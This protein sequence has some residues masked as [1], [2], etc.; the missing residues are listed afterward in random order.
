MYKRQPVDETPFTVAEMINAD[1]IIVSSSGSFCLSASE[2]DGK[3]VGG[4]APELMKK[5]QDALVDDYLR[6]TEK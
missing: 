2:I 1:E 6:E 5:L 3:P 4:R